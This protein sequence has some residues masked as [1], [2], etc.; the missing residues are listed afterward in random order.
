MQAVLYESTIRIDIVSPDFGPGL[1][2]DGG[3]H[4]LLVIGWLG[5]DQLRRAVVFEQHRLVHRNGP[6]LASYEE[7]DG[8]GTDTV[9]LLRYKKAFDQIWE[10]GNGRQSR[11]DIA[12]SST[13]LYGLVEVDGPI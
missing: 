5:E 13:S 3:P 1:L 9:F 10:F 8:Y 11:Y 12:R 2:Q 6:R 7:F 4:G